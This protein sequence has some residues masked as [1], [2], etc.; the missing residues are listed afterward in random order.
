MLRVSH[1]YAHARESPNQYQL[2]I[3]YE[4]SYFSDAIC[5]IQTCLNLYVRS[6]TCKKRIAEKQP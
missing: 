2:N 3:F 1:A 4:L 5:L 6:R